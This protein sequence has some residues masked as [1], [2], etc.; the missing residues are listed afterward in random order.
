MLAA[1]QGGGRN[2]LLQLTLRIPKIVHRLP[3][4]PLHFSPARPPHKPSTR[5]STGAAMQTQA[6]LQTPICCRSRQPVC[7][8]AAG[9]VVTAAAAAPSVLLPPETLRSARLLYATAGA[10]AHTYPGE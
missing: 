4:G 6:T 7:R 9:P 8:A 1:Q 5:C 3:N 2:G 10:P